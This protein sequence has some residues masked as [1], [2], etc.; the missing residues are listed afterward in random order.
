M[1]I[2]LQE[3]RAVLVVVHIRLEEVMHLT[4]FNMW[5]ARRTRFVPVIRELMF[6][7][8]VPQIGQRCLPSPKCCCAH[9]V[10]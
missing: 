8:S 1:T 6:Q 4:M 7:L 9:D 3:A 2:V 5:L 10:K